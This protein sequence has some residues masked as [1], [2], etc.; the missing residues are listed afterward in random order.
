MKKPD[1]RFLGQPVRYRLTIEPHHHNWL[2]ALD[3]PASTPGSTYIDAAGTLRTEKPIDTRSSYELVS[4]TAYRLQVTAP[5]ALLDY[6]RQL[7]P[8]GNPKARALAHHWAAKFTPHGVIEAALS[9]FR[10]QNY[11]YTL[12]P[13]PVSGINHIDQF[14]FQT[15]EG[16]CAQY[17]GAFT[18]LM[19]AAGL[20]ARVVTG[21]QGGQTGLGGDYMIIRGGNAHAWSEVWLPGQGWVRVDPTAAVSPARIQTGLAASLGN[22]EPVPFLLHS[23]GDLF[24]HLAMVWDYANASW[25]RWFLAYG[26]KLQSNFM[27]HLGLPTT[28]T[29]ILALTVLITLFLALLGAVLARQSRPPSPADPIQAAWLRLCRRLGRAGIPRHPAEGPLDY[30]KRVAK[31]HPDDADT[32]HNLA[33]RYARLRYRGGSNTERKQF[34]QDIRAYRPHR[35]FPTRQHNA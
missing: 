23:T 21:Y 13:E 25:N 32:I 31:A 19:R 10:D 5:K 34:L 30:A 27:Q 6:A 11:V 8:K 14:L 29:M 7:P 35:K 2:L 33:N 4:Y 15:R 24:Y 20:P 18:F 1:R 3:L 9:R 16:F 12:Q 28:R 22:D 17:A 26:P